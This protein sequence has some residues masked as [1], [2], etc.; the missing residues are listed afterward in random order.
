MADGPLAP[1][2]PPPDRAAEIAA[3]E[4]Q[5]LLEARYFRHAGCAAAIAAGAVDEVLPADR[6][7]ARLQALCT[8]TH[9]QL[10]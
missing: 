2:L 7:A 3:L 6:I 10:R 9:E 1:P 4:V 8:R 5:L